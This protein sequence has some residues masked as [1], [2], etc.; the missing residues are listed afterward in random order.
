MQLHFVFQ[1]R[2]TN[3]TPCGTS[4]QHVSDI[5]NSLEPGLRMLLKIEVMRLLFY[6]NV[7]DCKH[8]SDGVFERLRVMTAY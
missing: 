1:L 3:L 6:G 8:D 4:M 7:T 2:M 5:K